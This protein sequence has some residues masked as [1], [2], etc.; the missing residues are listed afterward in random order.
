MVRFAGVL[1]SV[2]S[3]PSRYGIGCFDK[4]AYRFVDWLVEAGQS[5]WQLL[6]L[7]P[8]GHGIPDDSPYQ[9]YSA[10]AGNP[11]LISLDKLIEEGVLTREEC[12]AADLESADGNVDYDKLFANRLKLLHTAYE[13]SNIGAN[14]EYQSFIAENGWWLSDY[15]LF[16]AL[17]D[18]FGTSW[19]QW[20]EDIRLHWG[21]SVEYY[22]RT[23]YYDVE[24]HKFMQFK[25][26]QQ[27]WALRHYANERGIELVGDMPIYVSMDSADV[28]SHPELFQLDENNEPYAV[29]GCPPDAFSATGQIWGN[30][31]Y[32]WDYHRDTGFDWWSS[33]IYQSFRLYDVL[34][35]DHFRGFDEYYSIPRG[36]TSALEGHWETG[37]RMDLFRTIEYR[38]GWHKVI[39]EDLGY[40]TDS[41]RALVKES[42]FPN[43]KVLEFG[44]EPDD[45]GA[46]NDYLPHNY[47][48][49]CAAYTGTHD[50][51]TVVGWFTSLTDTEKHRIR[52]YMQDFR[53][54][55][56]EMHWAFIALVMRS[57]ASMSIIPMQDYLGCDNSCRM[58]QPST[59]GVNWRWRLKGGELTSDLAE[60]ILELTRYTG[61][62]NWRIEGKE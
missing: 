37:P 54:P 21:Y 2:T 53:T 62:Y 23:L 18:F 56:N 29:A 17:K 3:L 19:T 28:W 15:A 38:L 33:R 10:F 9:A 31:L 42:G 8:T 11:Y 44:F 35:I 49:N 47:N 58:N 32:R 60:R 55:D 52:T 45:I 20:P 51:E 48:T 7:A 36:C 30:P 27:W 43:M 5:Y 34:R 26:F 1:L 16:M 41:V 13:R 59:V 46:A 40:M 6:P 4:E 24:F 14:G 57:A 39:A 12:D 22:H 61:R 50:N 25:F